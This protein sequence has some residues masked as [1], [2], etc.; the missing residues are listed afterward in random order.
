MKIIG[1]KTEKSN[2]EVEIDPQLVIWKLE[3]EW[4]RS[5]GIGSAWEV[6]EKNVWQEIDDYNPAKPRVIRHRPITEEEHEMVTAFELMYK[7][8]KEG[9][10]G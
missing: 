10:K 3:M 8:V 4:R 1:T 6:G 9:E 5:Q 7:L 2:V